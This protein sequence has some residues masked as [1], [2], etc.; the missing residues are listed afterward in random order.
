MEKLDAKRAWTIEPIDWVLVTSAVNI[1][2][3]VVSLPTSC[4]VISDSDVITTNI[5]D[6]LKEIGCE[7]RIAPE[8][9]VVINCDPR[10]VKGKCLFVGTE[11]PE[12]LDGFRQIITSKQVIPELNVWFRNG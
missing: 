4:Y 11:I 1:L 6:L 2:A 12:T 5:I 9:T 10:Y 8:I 3:E 7:F